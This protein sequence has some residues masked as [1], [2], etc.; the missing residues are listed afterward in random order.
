MCS[1]LRKRFLPRKQN[2]LSVVPTPAPSIAKEV[3]GDESEVVGSEAKWHW[4]KEAYDLKTLL[5]DMAEETDIADKRL[6]ALACLEQKVAGEMEDA[7]AHPEGS[8]RKWLQESSSAQQTVTNIKKEAGAIR[9]K[10]LRL[11]VQHLKKATAA[12]KDIAGGAEAGALWKAELSS[13]AS[14]A[15]IQSAM[16][17]LLHPSMAGKLQTSFKAVNK[18]LAYSSSN[19]SPR[20]RPQLCVCRM[21]GREVVMCS[22][23]ATPKLLSLLLLDVSS[24]ENAAPI[25]LGCCWLELENVNAAAVWEYS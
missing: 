4:L 3:Y 14:L 24:S 11:A 5:T 10:A 19:G 13:T 8:L 16:K 2:F 15:A 21:G 6:Q 12:C 20:S 7:S 22:S 1:L 18:E 17:N 25:C 23:V 9:D